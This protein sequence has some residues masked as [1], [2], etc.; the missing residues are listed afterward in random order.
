MYQ[1]NMASKKMVQSDCITIYIARRINKKGRKK[2]QAQLD[3]HDK[4][5]KLYRW[6][7]GNTGFQGL[8]FIFELPL[9]STTREDRGGESQL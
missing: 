7:H 4:P 5:C 8:A 6:S 1:E 9:Y 2:E 3:S